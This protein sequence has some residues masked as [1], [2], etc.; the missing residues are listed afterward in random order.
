MFGRNYNY[1]MLPLKVISTKSPKRDSLSLGLSAVTSLVT[2]LKSSHRV[3]AALGKQYIFNY[4]QLWGG[5]AQCELSS[6]SNYLILPFATKKKKSRLYWK[7]LRVACDEMDDTPVGQRNHPS[8][9]AELF[10]ACVSQEDLLIKT[11]LGTWDTFT[12]S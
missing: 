7:V 9:R 1:V 6:M 5:W 11:K 10:V 3:S 2:A 4:L 8:S 12:S